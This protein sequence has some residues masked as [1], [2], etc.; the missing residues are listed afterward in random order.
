MPDFTF[1]VFFLFS[2]LV[3]ACRILLQS[4]ESLPIGSFSYSATTAQPPSVEFAI[5]ISL[6]LF[7]SLEMTAFNDVQTE[8]CPSEMVSM[9]S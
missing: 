2:A 7:F 8:S 9:M 3:S 6:S 5:L 1:S 4:S